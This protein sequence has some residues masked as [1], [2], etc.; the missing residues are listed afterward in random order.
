[1]TE[2]MTGAVIDSVAVWVVVPNVAEMIAWEG[3]LTGTVDIVKVAVDCPADTET[4]LGTVAAALLEV[5]PT[6]DP[7][8]PAIPLRVKVPVALAPP[9]RV[10]GLR[11]IEASVAGVIVRFCENC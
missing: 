5:N 8:V 10:V 7:S 4:E 9:N 3:V 2:T 6:T 11:A 1:M